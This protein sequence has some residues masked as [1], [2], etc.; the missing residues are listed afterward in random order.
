MAFKMKG[1]AFYGHGNQS[2]TK[3]KGD[4]KKEKSESA[5]ENLLGKLGKYGSGVAGDPVYDKGEE[6]YQAST[7]KIRDLPAMPADETQEDED[8]VIH[9]PRNKAIIA[10]RSAD[11]K[12][13]QEEVNSE[14]MQSYIGRTSTS[15]ADT[16]K[17]N[18]VKKETAAA[19]AE[20]KAAEQAEKQRQNELGTS[21]R[22]KE[23]RKGG[24]EGRKPN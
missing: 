13:R 2:P 24:K 11:A 4:P 9:N 19:E 8:S 20:T 21:G 15:E 6:S 17:S 22:R 16:A 7:I 3:A 23:W 5:T 14:S 18:R 1:S 12:K 10:E